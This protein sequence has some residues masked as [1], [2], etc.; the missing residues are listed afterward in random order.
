MFSLFSII[1]FEGNNSRTFILP[2]DTWIL[3]VYYCGYYSG[4]NNY[5]YRIEKHF[6]KNASSGVN[7]VSSIPT[8]NDRS[9]WYGFTYAITV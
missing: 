8:P 9:Y 1:G 2:I 3:Q 4:N 7:N 5:S 6:V